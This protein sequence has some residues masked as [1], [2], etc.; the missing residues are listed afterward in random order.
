MIQCGFC[1]FIFTDPLPSVEFL[2]DFYQSYDSFGKSDNYYRYLRDLDESG[3]Y[4][5]LKKILNRLSKRYGFDKKN[6]ILDVGS[7]GGMFLKVLKDCDFVGL[8]LE[9]SQPAINFAKK[10]FSVDCVCGNIETVEL[11]EKF[12]A[13]FMWDLLEHLRYPEQVIK[14]IN[15]LLADGGLLVLETPNSGAL[16]NRI[17]KFILRIKI[18]W[19]AQWMFGYHHLSIFSSS[20][21]NILL[22]REGFELLEIKKV[23][24]SANRI[25]PFS[26]KFFIP[27]LALEVVNLVGRAFGGRNKIMLVARKK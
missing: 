11:S 3:E 23:N 4:N 10:N 15:G 14:K 19:P 21:L 24:T 25:F 16:I 12:S 8:G 1:G 2:D 13:V 26:F 17:I 7:G 6:K 5:R 18:V 20:S 27:R 9:I 22:E